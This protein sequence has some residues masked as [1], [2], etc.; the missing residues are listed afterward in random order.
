[1][2]MRGQKTEVFWPQRTAKTPAL[3]ETERGG[4]TA[5]ASYVLHHV[6]CAD[7]HCK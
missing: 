4:S 2:T 3:Q 7:E 5:E 6:K 1:M